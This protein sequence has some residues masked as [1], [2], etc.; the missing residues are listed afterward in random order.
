MIHHSNLQEVVN[1]YT[2]IH[3]YNSIHPQTHAY[4]HRHL[5]DSNHYNY[6]CHS[7]Y[8]YYS[9]TPTC[10]L[11]SHG[12]GWVF[13]SSIPNA[14]IKSADNTPAFFCFMSTYNLCSN[15]L[16]RLQYI[17]S[18]STESNIDRLQTVNIKHRYFTMNSHKPI[19]YP[20]NFP[21]NRL[22]LIYN[23]VHM[24]IYICAYT[25][26]L[27]HISSYKYMHLWVY[28]HTNI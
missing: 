25:C 13:L 14:N 21:S 22:I 18:L 6:S 24:N 27:I 16:N 15:M 2:H 20:I 9:T 3:T 26:E 12:V 1:A 7:Y 5:Q 23:H 19:N 11:I 4:K 28:V 17:Y 8:S 10:I